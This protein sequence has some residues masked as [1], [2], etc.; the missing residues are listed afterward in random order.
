MQV[1]VVGIGFAEVHKAHHVAHVGADLVA[2]GYP[3]FYPG[4][5]YIGANHRQSGH[6]GIVL[7][8][9]V[10]GE[11]EVAV[12]VVLVYR[13]VEARGLRTALHCHRLGLAA[14][15]RHDGGYPQAPKLHFGFDTEQ[16]LAALDEGRA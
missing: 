9:E 3:N 2:V 4:N 7:V 6:G 11:E 8:A 16:A 13:D 10:L 5:D 14:L 15:L 12:G 1:V